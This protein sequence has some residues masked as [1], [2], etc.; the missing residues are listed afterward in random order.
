MRRLARVATGLA[1]SLAVLCAF[2]GA[3][4]LLLFGWD[5][6]V[7]AEPTLAER[8]HTLHDPELGWVNARS[9]REHE[10]YGPGRALTT[11]ARGFRGSREVGDAIPSGKLRIVCSGDSFTL[12]YGV[13]DEHAWPAQLEQLDVRLETVNM[14]QGGYGLDQAY[15]WFARDAAS[16]QHDV[17]VFAFIADDFERMRSS[18]F[19]GYGK[20][21]LQVG[22][23][24]LIV[25]GVP[26]ALESFESPWWTQN[27]KRF[28]DL[29]L[30]SLARRAAGDARPSLPDQMDVVEAQAVAARIFSE[31]ARI[32]AAK[33][34]RLVLVYLPNRDPAAPGRLTRLLGWMQR[35]V[36]S[37]RASGTAW[38]DL[39]GDFDRVTESERSQLF[40]PRGESKSRR[41]AG[42]YSQAGNRFVAERIHARLDEFGAL[43]PKR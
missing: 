3:A 33:S 15:L 6:A 24:G 12:G 9:V 35:A 19:L 7:Y 27:S 14:G 25:G 36:E 10:L 31:L 1:L 39:T 43:A 17:H 2:E 22:A 4:S 41:A 16:L 34:S 28:F 13:G 11:N 30:L 23:S 40:I 29:R 8:A 26:V 37:A 20:P 42:H 21:R 5:L 32:N 38:I 18:R